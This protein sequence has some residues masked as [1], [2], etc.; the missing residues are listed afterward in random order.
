MGC[1]C[2]KNSTKNLEYVYTSAKGEQTVWTSIYQ[3]QAKQ[4]REGGGGN[5]TTREK[6]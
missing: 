4:I 3:A 6:K 2:R 1:N 5:I